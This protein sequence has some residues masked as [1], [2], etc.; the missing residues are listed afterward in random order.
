MHGGERQEEGGG[1]HC[2]ESSLRIIRRCCR[3]TVLGACLFARH[4]GTFFFSF[5]FSSFDFFWLGSFFFS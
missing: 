5:S 3:A 2:Y 1:C 4:L